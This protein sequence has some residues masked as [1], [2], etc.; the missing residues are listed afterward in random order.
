MFFSRKDNDFKKKLKALKNHR[1][2]YY[3]QI[4]KVLNLYDNYNNKAI[5]VTDVD[6]KSYIVEL[7]DLQYLDFEAFNIVWKRNNVEVIFYNGN[8]PL[9]EKGISF[10][11]NRQ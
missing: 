3:D 9:T 10:L 7:V 5:E 1:N 8:Y 4:V 2:N 6:L 11:K